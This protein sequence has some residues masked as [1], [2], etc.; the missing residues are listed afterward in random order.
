[1]QDIYK[2]IK[3]QPFTKS[4]KYSFSSQLVMLEEVSKYL[5]TI[6][7]FNQFF[8]INPHGVYLE[9]SKLLLNNIFD[10]SKV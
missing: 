3:A 7:D 6:L 1:L 8:Q 4:Y 9:D 2:I 5:E 10:W